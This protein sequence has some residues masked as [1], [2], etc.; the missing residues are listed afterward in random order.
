MRYARAAAAVLLVGMSV[1]GV[2]VARAQSGGAVLYGDT[3][4]L[5]G[6]V[7][8][9]GAGLVVFILARAHGQGNF[10]QVGRVRT[11]AGGRWR[12]TAQPK[13]FTVYRARVGRLLS[14]RV[15]VQVEP[16]ITLRRER[17]RFSA[18]VRAARSFAGRF[19]VLQRRAAGGAWR[20][21]RRLVLDRRSSARFAFLHPRTRTEIRLVLP[22]SQAGPGYVAARSGVITLLRR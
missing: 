22:S 13:I 10:R 11:T 12:F 7:E 3:F 21:V 2:A 20:D 17:G 19:V 9:S 1:I 16:R 8:E 5:T 18:T 4:E 15:V 6:D 14:G